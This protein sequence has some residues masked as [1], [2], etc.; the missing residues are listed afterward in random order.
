MMMDEHEELTI[1]QEH[2]VRNVASYAAEQHT[3]RALGRVWKSL[4]GLALIIL[5]QSFYVVYNTG[6]KVQ[7]QDVNTA[8]ISALVA[9]RQSDVA[10]RTVDENQLASMTATLN[11]MQMQLNRIE[12]KVDK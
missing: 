7:Q 1:P 11:Q 10:V 5:G 3:T 4:V 12:N 8:Q 9:A 6:A 2:L